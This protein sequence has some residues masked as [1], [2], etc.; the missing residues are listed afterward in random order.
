MQPP[1]PIEEQGVRYPFLRSLFE[2]VLHEEYRKRKSKK[3]NCRGP[4]KSY[5][6]RQF[7]FVPIL[8]WRSKVNVS[9][10]IRIFKKNVDFF[11]HCSA[12]TNYME[13][14]LQT[15][16]I[17]NFLG[18]VTLLTAAIFR[19]SCNVD[20]SYFPFDLQNCTMRF[21]SWTQDK[22]RVISSLL[23]PSCP[24]NLKAKI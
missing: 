4:S 14:L 16:V 21:M 5:L 9:V 12:A 11:T 17:V 20:V 7:S 24:V 8:K 23:F 19:S 3:E 13:R 6:P 22:T 2:C 18:E 15:N 1:S 10:D